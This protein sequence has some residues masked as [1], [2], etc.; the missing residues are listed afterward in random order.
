[1]RRQRVEI[2][3]SRGQDHVSGK[4]LTRHDQAHSIQACPCMARPYI[5]N[6]KKK[7][8]LSNREVLFCHRFLHADAFEE[9]FAVKRSFRSFCPHLCHIFIF[10]TV[11][12]FGQ[13]QKG[14]M[15]LLR[16]LPPC[17]AALGHL[18]RFL[19][20]TT[21]VL[22]SA[23]SQDVLCLSRHGFSASST[24]HCCSKATSAFI[25]AQEDPGVEVFFKIVLSSVVLAGYG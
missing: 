8:P 4:N 12:V 1:M 13:V 11:V 20:A 22:L 19:S 15:V 2:T 17:V 23:D 25:T 5:T 6:Q 3:P 14:S 18:Q 21:S 10:H 24:R 9:M 7:T 16:V